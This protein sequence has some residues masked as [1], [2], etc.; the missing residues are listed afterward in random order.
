M[1]GNLA[2]SNMPASLYDNRILV[3]DDTTLNRELISSY[4]K[5]E[6]Y[7]NIHTAIDGQD[8]LAK[9]EEHAP[10]LLILDLVMPNING[11]EVIKTLRG[12]SKTRNLPI[13]VQ[14]MIT[15]PEERKEAWGYGATDV[16]IKPIHKLEL[17]SRVKVQ[18][19]NS[20]LL[21]TLEGYQKVASEEFTRALDFQ[22]DLLPSQLQLTELYEKYHLKVD[23]M[24]LPSRFLSGDIWGIYEIAPEK[25]MIW[26]C[27]F[28]GKGISA[29]LSTFRLHTLFLE[30]RYKIARPGELMNILNKRLK[31]LIPVGHF[32]TCLIGLLDIKSRTLTYAAAGST[33]P[34]VY[35]P[36]Q[37][38][39][40]LGNGTGMPLGILDDVTY[41]ERIIDI[42]IGASLTL[43]SDV[44]WDDVGAIPGVSFLSENLPDFIQGLQGKSILD[45]IRN[46]INLLGEKSFSDDLTLIELSIENDAK[47]EIS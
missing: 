45:V 2:I 19:Q 41:E 35:F 8:A 6:G 16:I 14:T 17:L 32:C 18:L 28:S 42:P 12:H 40:D 4:L 21:R 38:R 24:F 1:S 13:L 5:S 46:H 29:S 44:L 3:V 9:I 39:F 37:Q 23:S 20:Y 33:H 31:E 47:E 11:I 30:Y 7:R 43:Y 25:V 10:D 22:M 26:I 34:I 15:D 36:E 27:D